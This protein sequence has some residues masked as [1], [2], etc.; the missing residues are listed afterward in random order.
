M[1]ARSRNLL[2]AGHADSTIISSESNTHTIE[3]AKQRGSYW[4]STGP[5]WSWRSFR[6]YICD[7]RAW[8]IDGGTYRYYAAGEIRDRIGVRSRAPSV[9][10]SSTTD[11]DVIKDVVETLEQ[12]AT[13]SRYPVSRL[14]DRIALKSPLRVTML[15]NLTS[16]HDIRWLLRLNCSWEVCEVCKCSFCLKFAETLLYWSFSDI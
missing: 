6:Y 4:R 2:H 8:D 11:I 3:V 9:P 13:A 10:T 1:R 12:V 15:G 16:Y 7:Y 5:T 14:P